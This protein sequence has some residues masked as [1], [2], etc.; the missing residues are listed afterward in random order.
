MQIVLLFF[1][2]GFLKFKLLAFSPCF[3]QE[4]HGLDATS[5]FSFLNFFLIVSARMSLHRLRHFFYPRQH[6]IA[7]LQAKEKIQN[8]KTNQNKVGKITITKVVEHSN[9]NYLYAYT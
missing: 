9:L 5:P 3:G 8:C 6:F 2:L 1:Q 4:Q 7:H